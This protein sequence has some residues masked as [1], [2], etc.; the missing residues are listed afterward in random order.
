MC[1]P[2]SRDLGD[3]AVH[4]AAEAVK[5]MFRFAS[6]GME[7]S[8]SLMLLHLDLTRRAPSKPEVTGQA[9]EGLLG[10]KAKRRML[11]AVDPALPFKRG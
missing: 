8:V 11:A 10:S 5:H 3:C 1:F 7:G 4:G 6:D 2:V 9:W